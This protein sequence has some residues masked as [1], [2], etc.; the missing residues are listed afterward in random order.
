MAPNSYKNTEF[1][2]TIRKLRNKTG[3]L[4]STEKCP[5][6][7]TEIQSYYDLMVH[8]EKF[9]PNDVKHRPYLKQIPQFEETFNQTVDDVAMNDDNVET[10]DE[11]FTMFQTSD[12]IL[13][14][15]TLEQLKDNPFFK[16]IIFII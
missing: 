11:E 10:I 12:S 7:S 16:V 2:F 5:K 4:D 8:I 13:D 3:N 6:C 14:S 1:Q 9:H 15:S